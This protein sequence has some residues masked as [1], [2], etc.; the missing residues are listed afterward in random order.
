MKLTQKK[1]DD[2]QIEL[3]VEVEAAEFSKTIKQTTKSLGERISVPGFRKGKV[4]PKIVEAHIGKETIINE[5]SNTLLQQSTKKALTTLNLRPV[6][7]NKA[8]VI[9]NEEGKDFV[10]TLTFTP[11][12]QAKLGEYKNLEAEKVVE[13]V[14]EEEVDKQIDAMRN[15]H[16][17]LIDAAEGDAIVDGDFITLDYTGTIDGEKFA[18][19]EAKDAPLDIGSHKFIGDFEEQLIGLKVGEEK[20]IKVTFPDDYHA[21]NLA[22]KEAEFACKINSIK[23]KELPELNDE[24]VQKVTTFKTVDEYKASVRKSMEANAERRAVEAQQQAV[25]DK[26]VAN[27]EVDLPPVMI[28]NRI[29][30]IINELDAQFKTQGMDIQKYMAFSGIDMDRLREDSRERA[31]KEVL[32]DI[33]IERVAEAEKISATEEDINMEIAMMSQMY[34]TPAKQLV[35]YLRDNGQFEIVIGNIIRRKTMKFIIANMAGAKPNDL[36]EDFKGLE[37]SVEKKDTEE[38]LASKP[39]VQSVEELQSRAK[40]VINSRA[41]T[42]DTAPAEET[43][44]TKEN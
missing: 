14:T 4:P 21:K 36:A 27:M 8:N 44:E 3:T 35:K 25:I 38:E 23:H 41:I 28:E 15:H 16:A 29:T 1:I 31:K 17:N 42:K 37:A 7:E 6:T 13:P 30:Q 18:G 33:M 5:A 12:P 11:Y 9:T 32:T 20:T 2:Y 39:S 19:G 24:F 40:K 22:G 26:A 10:F 34:Q 43:T